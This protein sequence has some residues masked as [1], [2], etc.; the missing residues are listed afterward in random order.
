MQMGQLESL[1]ATGEREG[2]HRVSAPLGA[3]TL[4]PA[5]RRIFDAPDEG[6]VAQPAHR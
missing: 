2:T 6:E 4:A 3:S 5:G 1:S